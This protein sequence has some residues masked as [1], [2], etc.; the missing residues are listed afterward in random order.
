ML[1]LYFLFF[2]QD[3]PTEFHL[4]LSQR[5]LDGGVIVIYSEFFVLFF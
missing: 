2:E 1:L 3:V 5:R 4:A